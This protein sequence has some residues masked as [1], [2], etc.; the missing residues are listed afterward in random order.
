MIE[1]A[2]GFVALAE[3]DGQPVAAGVFLRFGSSAVYKF[4]ASDPAA[5]SSR[6]NNLVMWEAIRHLA[7]SGC[8][9][10]HFG[11]TRPDQA[12]L[13][14]F[15]CSWGALEEPIVYRRFDVPVGTWLPTPGGSPGRSAAV[16]KRLP[17]VLNRIA[18]SVAY[19][20]LD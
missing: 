1:T 17:L 14:R 20:H 16:F 19:R 5:W 15:K 18:G 12:G 3:A 6:P 8:R 2:Q 7:E 13:K 11:R 4:G 9:S 10:L